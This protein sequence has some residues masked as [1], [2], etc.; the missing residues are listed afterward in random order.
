MTQTVSASGTFTADG[1]VAVTIQVDPHRSTPLTL[2]GDGNDGGGTLKVQVT[3]DGNPANATDLTGISLTAA[4]YK[5]LPLIQG[6]FLVVLSGSTTPS[7]KW[8]L[9]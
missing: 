2:F 9:Q 4:G 7:L 5:V 3:P 8:W 6:C 1:S